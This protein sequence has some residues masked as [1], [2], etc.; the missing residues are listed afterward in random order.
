MPTDTRAQDVATDEEEETTEQ[1]TESIAD[2]QASPRNVQGIITPAYGAD[3]KRIIDRLNQ[4]RST[5]IVSYLQYKQHAYM[6]VSLLGP[7]V[8]AEF[9]EHADEE[10]RH[11]DMI[12]ERI[13]QLGG[14][15]LYD[16]CEIAQKAASQQV[17]PEQGT[18]L[19]Q[20]VMADLEV[21]RAQVEAYRAFIQEVGNHD[22]VTRRMLEDIL[23]DTEHHASELQG[24][25]QNRA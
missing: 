9:I 20:M 13:S 24:M 18:T 16:L 10:L 19:E 25:L 12:A 22:P 5:E 8:K 4:L 2:L 14:I 17:R 7:G 1:Q 11:A 3:P 21:E 23:I 15:P 6:A